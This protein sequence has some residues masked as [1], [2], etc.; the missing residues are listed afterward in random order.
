M[1]TPTIP[2]II[3]TLDDLRRMG[4]ENCYPADKL[5]ARRAAFLRLLHDPDSVTDIPTPGVTDEQDA[6]NSR[7]F[8]F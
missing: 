7:P 8:P 1:T 2:Q 6:I 5:A 3:D 4:L